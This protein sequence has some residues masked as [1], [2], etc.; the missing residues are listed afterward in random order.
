MREYERLCFIALITF[1][2]FFCY[3]ITILRH[4]E[5]WLDKDVSTEAYFLILIAL[6]RPAPMAWPCN[7]II[8]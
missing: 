6:R 5:M 1:F 7:I 3:Q 4:G 8:I 2:Q